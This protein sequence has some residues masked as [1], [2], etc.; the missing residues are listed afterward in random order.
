M[1][2]EEQVR[3]RWCDGHG[4]HD[5]PSHGGMM[6]Q[7]EEMREQQQRTRREAEEL[8]TRLQQEEGRMRELQAK[9]PP[10]T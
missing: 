2:L 3:V 6:S 8:R 7:V 9:A 4:G 10:P 5:S 1:V